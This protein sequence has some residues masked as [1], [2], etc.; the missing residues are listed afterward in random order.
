[1]AG[2]GWKRGQ[3]HFVN[4]TRKD[5]KCINCSH[6]IKK[7]SNAFYKNLFTG[8]RGYMHTNNECLQRKNMVLDKCKK[9]D[10]NENCDGLCGRS[11]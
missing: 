5:H 7:G 1:M 6:I 8:K 10:H 9:C 11:N 2:I 3:Q 4:K